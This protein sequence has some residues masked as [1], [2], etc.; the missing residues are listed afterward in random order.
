MNHTNSSTD[1]VRLP[2]TW[3]RTLIMLLAV[4]VCV[5]TG[6]ALADDEGDDPDGWVSTGNHW[7]YEPRGGATPRKLNV[8]TIPGTSTA[9]GTFGSGLTAAPGN[10]YWMVTDSNVGSAPLRLV[11]VR[12]NGGD[13]GEIIEELSIT[14]GAATLTGAMFDPEDVAVAP[15]GSFWLCDESRPWLAHVS[16]QGELIQRVDTPASFRSRVNNQGL[17]GCAISED[18]ATLYAILQSGLSTEPDKLN[19]L[20]LAYDIAGGTFKQ[21]RYRLD[22]PS[23]EPYAAGLK[24]RLGANALAVVGSNELYVLE[25]DNLTAAGGGLIKRVYR[26]ELPPEPDGAPLAKTII[27]D[28]FALGY[29]FEK[30]EGMTV[31]PNRIYVSNDNDK[32]ST[33]PNEVWE[34]SL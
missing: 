16:R 12:L 3:L 1:V 23:L 4:S 32:L 26:V 25:R 19:T 28:L 8:H 17:E 9:P 33:I 6:A 15:D 21:Y 5:V 14:E 34:L 10:T 18:G 24:P 31:R 11:H 20:L 13:R 30:C 7:R 22:D 27:V 2:R 29:P